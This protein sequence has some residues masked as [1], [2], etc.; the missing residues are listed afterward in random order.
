[1][2]HTKHDT[3]SHS[4]THKQTC[5]NVWFCEHIRDIIAWLSVIYTVVKQSEMCGS[6]SSS[7]NT[8]ADT[9]LQEEAALTSGSS[10]VTAWQSAESFPAKQAAARKL[11][12]PSEGCASALLDAYC[13]DC[14]GYTSAMEGS[15]EANDAAAVDLFLFGLEILQRISSVNMF[16][17]HKADTL[18]RNSQIMANRN[19]VCGCC[20]WIIDGISLLKNASPTFLS[21]RGRKQ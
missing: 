10:S 15:V 7:V 11:K 9:P 19:I 6:C 21:H 2:S 8:C 13:I 12:Q 4:D 20:V 17:M 14:P 5:T 3:R 1:M 18:E 16:L